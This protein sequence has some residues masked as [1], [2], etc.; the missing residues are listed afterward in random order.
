MRRS[1]ATDQETKESKA[2]KICTSNH[3]PVSTA[4][5]DDPV[6]VVNSPEWNDQQS[7]EQT[8]VTCEEFGHH[9]E[10]NVRSTDHTLE[11]NQQQCEA[12]KEVLP[13]ESS[14][15]VIITPQQCS[16]MSRSTT[17][18]Q[19]SHRDKHKIVDQ[20]TFAEATYN[21]YCN[22]QQQLDLPK[23]GIVPALQ[24][25]SNLGDKLART[26]IIQVRSRGTFRAARRL[27]FRKQSSSSW[28]KVHRRKDV[29]DRTA[30]FQISASNNKSSRP[31]SVYFGPDRS[32]GG[33][34]LG[35]RKIKD[36]KLFLTL[37]GRAR[38]LNVG[39]ARQFQTCLFVHCTSLDNKN[40]RYS[41]GIT[42]LVFR[43]LLIYRYT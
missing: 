28:K 4:C 16:T 2:C 26:T 43:A 10:L 5:E 29:K 36:D 37:C 13:T 7:I 6:V 32:K 34:M 41:S 39:T 21:D 8:A 23:E 24:P 40:Y 33:G 25:G 19:V 38:S 3:I 20:D 35:N 42:V 31:I 27:K 14:S 1:K 15:S 9:N 22:S 12:V 17:E 11:H 30:R 18:E